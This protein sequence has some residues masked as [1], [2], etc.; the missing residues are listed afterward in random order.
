MFWQERCLET[1]FEMR[2]TACCL[3]SASYHFAKK[4]LM[5]NI[6]LLVAQRKC[7][8]IFSIVFIVDGRAKEQHLAFNYKGFTRSRLLFLIYLIDILGEIVGPKV[9][10][11]TASLQRWPWAKVNVK[12]KNVSLYIFSSLFLI[13]LLLYI[14]W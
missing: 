10:T 8:I 9:I 12:I 5:I 14:N 11:F 3:P 6:E 13:K 2:M 1:I 7:L 4:S